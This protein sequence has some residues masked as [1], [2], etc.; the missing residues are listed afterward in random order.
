MNA[1][2]LCLGVM[3]STFLLC[4]LMPYLRE[5]QYGFGIA[6]LCVV[7]PAALGFVIFDA[8]GKAWEKH[9]RSND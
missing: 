9:K 8:I 6:F 7:I 1:L 2:G 4:Y 3:A 5:W